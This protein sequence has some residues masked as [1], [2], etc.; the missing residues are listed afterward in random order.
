MTKRPKH[1][2]GKKAGLGLPGIIIA[3]VID[4]KSWRDSDA[5]GG[6]TGNIRIHTSFGSGGNVVLLLRHVCTKAQIRDEG[7]KVFFGKF[8]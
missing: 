3:P 7:T 1:R 8:A 6:R 5:T 4:E 2:L